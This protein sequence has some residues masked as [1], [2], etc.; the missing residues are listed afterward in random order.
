M[1]PE[2]LQQKDHKAE[3]VVY[4]GHKQ[5]KAIVYPASLF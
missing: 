3:V 2:V 4:K 5:K 1:I